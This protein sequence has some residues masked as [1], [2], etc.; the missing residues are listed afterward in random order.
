[1]AAAWE[2][3]AP[4]AYLAQLASDAS[5]RGRMFAHQ[6]DLPRLP[7]PDLQDACA[8]YVKAVRP[9]IRGTLAGVDAAAAAALE[10]R[11]LAAVADFVRPGGRGEELH[12]RLLAHE[13]RSRERGDANWLEQWWYYAAYHADRVPIPVHSN[14]YCV[15]RDHPISVLQPV[16]WV[17]RAA[18]LIHHAMV[19]SRLI[20]TGDLPA[21]TAGRRPLC[22][23][24]YRRI[25]RTCRLPGEPADRLVTFPPELA[26]HIV[27]MVRDHF[28]CVDVLE[29]DLAPRA[30]AALLA[31]LEA[32]LA[33]A[34]TLPDAARIGTLT[35][36]ERG[37]WARAYATLH[38]H[39]PVNAA[40]LDAIA[41]A[42]MVVVF[43]EHTPTT[44]TELGRLALQG[45]GHN[46][47]F[48]KTIQLFLF[49]NGRLGLN[50]EH[51]PGDA[52]P[53]AHGFMAFATALETADEYVALHR[54][55]RWG[56]A[57]SL[58]APPACSPEPIARGFPG[59]G[60]VLAAGGSEGAC[61]RLLMWDV[62]PAV[63]RAIAAATTTA[64][65][66]I[67]SSQL[68]FL[69]YQPYGMEVRCSGC[70]H[71]WGRG[72]ADPWGAATRILRRI[73]YP[74]QGGPEPR[75][76]PADGDAAGVLPH[77]WSLYL[78]L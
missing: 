3:R 64:T 13:A 18:A 24:Q 25:F 11:T 62:P 35:Y 16:D 23:D 46:R 68:E 57:S 7:V 48:D 5:L 77:L 65:R 2:T 55:R 70:V 9:V 6:K 27:V 21:D 59:N 40:S 39:A 4:A 51:S 14:V 71:R 34:E 8:R 66:L 53:T 67:Q 44:R 28:F 50:G 10:E 56:P 74:G 52:P 47:Y 37:A 33:L 78:Y 12:R 20:D 45:A 38:A 60:G 69:E 61:W 1:M 58:L 54:L 63:H 31:D 26:R 72:H 29:A 75:L 32:V 36:E 76:V 22:M 15:S 73:V 17:C 30:P 49:R 42:Q 19:Y 43:D 41:R